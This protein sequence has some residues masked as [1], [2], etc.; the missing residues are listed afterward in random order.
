MADRTSIPK[1]LREHV[2]AEFNSLCAICG[3]PRPQLHHIDHDRTNN[4]APNLIPL[5]PNH[6][7]LDAHNPTEP[8]SPLRLSLFR[9]FKNPYILLPQFIPLLDRLRFLIVPQ[10]ESLDFAQARNRA[11]DLLLFIS[12]LKM[13]GYYAA[14]LESTLRWSPPPPSDVMRAT[15]NILEGMA[16][17]MRQDQVYEAKQAKYLQELRDRSS[18]IVRLVIESLRFQEWKAPLA[19][20]SEA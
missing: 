18:E 19:T 15:A 13:G 4:A 14:T 7:L 11:E 2:L 12:N 1:A 5:C 9:K 10:L 16:R 20:A 3:K 17:S 8:E 6:H